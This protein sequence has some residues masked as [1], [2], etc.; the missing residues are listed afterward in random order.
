MHVSHA[1]PLKCHGTTIS[2]YHSAMPVSSTSSLMIL[3]RFMRQTPSK[4]KPNYEL[5]PPNAQ[6]QSAEH[7][8]CSLKNQHRVQSWSAETDLGDVWRLFPIC[9]IACATYISHSTFTC[10]NLDSS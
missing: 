8:S 10:S 9:A 1:S 2:T 3:L 5:I 6:G 7:T 4:A